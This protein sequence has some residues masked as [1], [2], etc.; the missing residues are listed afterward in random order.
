MKS[1][2]EATIKTSDSKNVEIVSDI[3]EVESFVNQTFFPLMMSKQNFRTALQRCPL[4]NI[5]NC[6]TSTIPKSSMDLIFYRYPFFPLQHSKNNGPL[7]Q[8]V[9]TS[10]LNKEGLPRNVCQNSLG[11]RS[12][13]TLERL[14]R[15]ERSDVSDVPFHIY[16][17]LPRK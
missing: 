8:G 10:V 15:W 11:K 17:S 5:R 2:L 7:L 14:T 16:M 13:G 1:E 6:L 3:K 4:I 12:G 9:T